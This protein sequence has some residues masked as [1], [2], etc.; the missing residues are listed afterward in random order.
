[1]NFHLKCEIVV[2]TDNYQYHPTSCLLL[3]SIDLKLILI[4]LNLVFF[5]ISMNKSVNPSINPFIYF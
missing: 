2:Y 4:F 1:M 5:S 3:D